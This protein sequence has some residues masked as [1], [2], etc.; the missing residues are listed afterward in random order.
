MPSRDHP[1]RRMCCADHVMS[2]RIHR[3]VPV[4]L[5]LVCVCVTPLVSF[6]I[7]I[8]TVKVGFVT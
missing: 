5:S 7:L 6:I 4:V 2:F 8:I 1:G 3:L